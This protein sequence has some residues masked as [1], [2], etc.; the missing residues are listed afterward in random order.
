MFPHD[1]FPKKFNRGKHTASETRLGN[2]NEL[3]KIDL[4]ETK[5][6]K[7][8]KYIVTNVVIHYI[9]GSSRIM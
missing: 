8:V 2:Q 6:V 5:K 1:V 3:N 4:A 7:T 9:D